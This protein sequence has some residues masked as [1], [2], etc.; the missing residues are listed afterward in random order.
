MKFGFDYKKPNIIAEIGCNHMGKIEITY[1]NIELDLSGNCF[2]GCSVNT[3]RL[4][5]FQWKN[6]SQMKQFL[7]CGEG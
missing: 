4:G 3:A 2:F 6:A 7:W 5:Q 1:T